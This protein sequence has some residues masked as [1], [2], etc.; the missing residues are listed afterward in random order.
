[1]KSVGKAFSEIPKAFTVKPG[2]TPWKSFVNGVKM[3]FKVVG[4]LVKAAVS[5]PKAILT[6]A[7]VAVGEVLKP[8]FKFAG[9][10]LSPVLKPLGKALAPV[11]KFL[12]KTLAPVPGPILKVYDAVMAPFRDILG[13]VFA[14]LGEEITE[15]TGH[16]PQPLSGLG[17]FVGDI[18]GDI[19][20]DPATWMEVALTAGISTAIRKG[21]SAAAKKAG[22]KFVSFREPCMNS[23]AHLGYPPR[24]TQTLH[25]GTTHGTESTASSGGPRQGPHC[26]RSV[27]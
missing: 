15:L 12:G 23:P 13:P 20:G 19:V 7:F 21:A 5:I 14:P 9:K 27:A 3:P 22:Q 2:K 10:V 17:K 26:F 6:P 16:L 4:S 11:G 1:V 24:V 18:V 8:V 25:G